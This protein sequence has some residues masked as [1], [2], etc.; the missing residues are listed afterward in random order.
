M[1]E[2]VE[3]PA[4]RSALRFRVRVRPA[5]PHAPLPLAGLLALLSVDSGALWPGLVGLRLTYRVWPRRATLGFLAG[6]AVLAGLLQLL[7]LDAAAVA[8]PLAL[9]T[10]VVAVPVLRH[11]RRIARLRPRPG[12]GSP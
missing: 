8:G 1:A 12:G 9:A 4:S 3:T 11:S 5:L 6:A 7:L 2:G 10:V